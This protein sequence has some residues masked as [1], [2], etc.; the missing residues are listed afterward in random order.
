MSTSIGVIAEDKSDV[1]VVN[2]LIQKILPQKRYSIKSF[3]GHGCGKIRGKCFHWAKD[4]KTKGCSTLILLHDLDEHDWTGLNAEL[5][6]ALTNCSIPKHVVII[7][8]KEIEA[9]LLSDNI[10]INRA[11]KL[12]ENISPITNPQA[13]VNP[14]KRLGE[15]IYLRS[16]KTKR[17]LNSAHN[18]IIAAELD[19]ENVRKCTSFLPLEKFVIENI[20]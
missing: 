2:E 9:W 13:I 10:A 7:P 19:L 3:V 11:M 14:K 16:G 1:D 8:I 20:K 15:I 5:C 12:V 18:R 17:Y 4:L 6:Q